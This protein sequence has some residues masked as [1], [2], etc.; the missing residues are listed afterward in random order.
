MSEELV[1]IVIVGA[2]GF[3]QEVHTWLP[4]V[5]PTET[6]RFRGFLG[7]ADSSSGQLLGDPCE[8]SPQP[9][10]RFILA[11]GDIDARRRVTESL[12]SRGGRFIDFV[13]PLSHIASTAKMGQ[14]AVIYPY[15]L[16]SNNA[17][18]GDFVH[19]SLYASVGHDAHAGD[20]CY[21]APYA[22]LNGES[23]IGNDVL[24]GSHA[25]VASRISIG[26]NTRIAA[27][28]AA[29]RDAPENSVIV[30]VPGRCVSRLELQEET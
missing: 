25:T 2:G 9:N 15:A 3:A 22:T 23:K 7:R 20:N 26:N 18:L 29:M 5:F 19:L 4:A 12:V 11:I 28:S 1:E 14:G 6:H 24:L 27:N 21:L 10:D 17:T 13:H 8:Y 30:G 16:L